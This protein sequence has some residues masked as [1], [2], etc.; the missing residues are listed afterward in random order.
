M[1]ADTYRAPRLE[2][3]RAL[4]AAIVT[5]S[6]VAAI[7]IQMPGAGAAAGPSRIAFVSDRDG[8]PEIFTVAPDGSGLQRLTDNTA[9]DT[10][11]AWSPD[12]TKIAFSSNRDGDDDIYVMTASGTSV[13]NLT[14]SGTGR[15]V[16]PDW[17]P[18]G[19]KIAFVRGGDVHVVPAAGGGAPVKLGKGVAPA[20][21]PDGKK[22]A[23]IRPEQGSNDVY[24]MN[25]DGSRA[26][27]LTSG[28]E[29]DQPDWSPDGTQIAVEST[30]G[31]DGESR[32]VVINSD[33]TGRLELPGPGE[34]FAPSWSPD[35]QS[36]A[37]TSVTLDADVVVATLTGTRRS[38][39]TGNSYDFLPAWSPCA[40]NCPV[41]SPSGSPSPTASGTATPTGSPTVTPTGPE[42]EREPSL[43][44]LQFLKTKRQI[45]AA[46]AV[47]PA[48]PGRTVRVVLS[49]RR[50]GRWVKVAV[51]E[52]L[53]NSDGVYS[54]RF[55]NPA[56]TKRCRLRA[57]FAGDTDHLPS[58]KTKRFRC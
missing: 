12:S 55:R 39:V 48:H 31:A 21:S 56:R 52:P 9:W 28:L 34:D 53:M 36:L 41:V 42:G 2:R 18:D 1:R 49:K 45:K 11:P 13:T 10:E 23:V 3:A 20:W 37:L 17:S 22:L 24:L 43:L 14:N 29:A 40:S 19:S 16:Q 51:K 38:L 25:P 8:D 35:G 5:C 4:L 57:S 44:S 27:A 47:R 54:T 6:L 46:G 33:G 30:A 58:G 50:G 26:T 15:D 7:A 32:V